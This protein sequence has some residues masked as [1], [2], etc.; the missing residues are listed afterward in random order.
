MNPLI[1]ENDYLQFQGGWSY[2]PLE[3]KTF[4]SFIQP[5]PSYKILEFGS[6]SS[7][8]ILYD[9]IERFCEAIEYDTYETDEAYKVVHKNV[10]S[11]MY[12]INEIDDVSTPDKE[13][14]IIIVDGPTGVNRYKWYEKI[15]N[16]V[17][18]DTIILIDDYNHYKEFENALNANFKYRI[19]SASDVPFVPHGEHS[20]RI[21]TDI[22]VK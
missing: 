17:K 18:Y 20:W 16:N 8:Q 7:T 19:L 6:G 3:M 1:N 5:K 4:L 22:E 14:D 9:I 12:N 11:I 2:T 15:R 21:I 10:N 13:Y